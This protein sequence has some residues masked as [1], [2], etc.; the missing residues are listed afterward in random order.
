MCDTC[1]TKQGPFYSTFQPL[2]GRSLRTCGPIQVEKETGRLIGRVAACNERRKKLELAWYGPEHK[3]LE[4][5]KLTQ[6]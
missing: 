5:F 3:E 4:L 2:V 6:E 1:G